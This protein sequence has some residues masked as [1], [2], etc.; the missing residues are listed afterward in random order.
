MSK[1]LPTTVT[2]LDII[3]SLAVLI[4]VIDHLGMYFFPEQLWL[5]AIGRIGMPVWFFMVGYASG[6]DISNKLLIGAGILA[7]ADLFLFNKVFPFSALVTI[8]VIRLSIDPVMKYILQGRYIFI[9]ACI[10]MTLAFF[11][12]NIVTEYGTLALLFAVMGYLTRHKAQLLKETFMNKSFYMFF[13]SYL[14]LVFCFIQ[15]IVFGFNEAQ[16]AFMAVLTAIVMIILAIMKSMTF[17]QISNPLLKQALQFGGRK[18]LEIY[19][20]HL[21]LFKLLLLANLALK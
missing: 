3:K 17:P 9:M 5:R 6:R 19:V 7:F 12:T 15:D 14:F 8:I 2:H 4:M 16:L 21:V 11:P 18:T 1:T 20:A 13:V 10:I